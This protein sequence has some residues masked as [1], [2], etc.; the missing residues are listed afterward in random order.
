MPDDKKLG[1]FQGTFGNML[2]MLEERPKINQGG[3]TTAFGADR[4]IRSYQLFRDLYQDHDNHV[5]QKSMLEARI[6]DIWIGDRGRHEENFNWAGFHMD[7]G[8]LFKPIPRDRDQAFSRLDGII[9]WIIDQPF[10]LP[11]FENFD[12]QIG[13]HTSL[14]YSARHLDRFLLTEATEEDW[15]QMAKQLQQIFS[16]SI[17]E[18]AIRHLPKETYE[19]TDQEIATKLKSRRPSLDQEVRKYYRILA[20]YVDVVGS[21]KREYFDV[22]RMKDGSVHVRMYDLASFNEQKPG[23]KLLYDR[24]FFSSETKEI[25][26]YGLGS[27]DVLRI[28]GSCKRSILLRIFGG[29]GEDTILDESEVRQGRRKSL[30]YELKPESTVETGKGRKKKISLQS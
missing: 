13:D 7:D 2:G 19:L 24:A 8:M 10:G 9:P 20:K 18:A 27:K 3:E 21:N 4:I 1:A 25:R 15:V 6:F 5:D 29:D 23:K 26:L 22:E 12:A 16:D 14:N 17:I 30:I 28:H 11:F